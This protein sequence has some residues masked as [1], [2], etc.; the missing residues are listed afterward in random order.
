MNPQQKK[1]TK[2][3]CPRQIGNFRAGFNLSVDTP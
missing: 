2:I 3:E 1:E